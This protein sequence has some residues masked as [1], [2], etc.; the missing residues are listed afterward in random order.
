MYLEANNLYACAIL[1]PLPTS[2]F[3]WL[4]DKEMEELDVM[5]VPDDSPRGYILGCDLGKYLYIH[6]YFIKC[7]VCFLYISGYPRDFIKCNVSFLCI[8]EYPHE[9][10]DLHKDYLLA[11]EHLQIEENI[12]CYYQRHLLQNEGFMK[13]SPKLVPNLCNKTNYI[14]YYHNLNLYLE[15]GLRLTNTNVHC[16]LLFNQ[17][18]CSKNYISVNICQRTAAKNDFEKDFFRLMNN[19]V[20]G[21]PFICLS[22]LIY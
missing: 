12:I 22:V 7:N 15:L 17:S 8:S 13:P 3:K 19:V 1:Q 5:M 2:N 20:F 14:T 11:P 4:T 6:A 18:P 10:H 16:A 21:K 9:L